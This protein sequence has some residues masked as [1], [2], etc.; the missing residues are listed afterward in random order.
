MTRTMSGVG[1]LSLP[2]S[3]SNSSDSETTIQ[4]SDTQVI[5]PR[6]INETRFEFQRETASSLTPQNTTPSIGVQGNFS[7]GGSNSGT[8]DDASGP[9]G[10]AELYVD[11]VEQEL[12]SD[13]REGAERRRCEQYDGAGP[14]VRLLTIAC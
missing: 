9:S 3:G 1:G 11:S 8:F 12:Y 5:N 4:I 14:M 6:V 13:G 2:G 10:S 7:S